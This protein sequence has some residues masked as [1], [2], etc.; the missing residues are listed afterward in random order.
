MVVV[1]FG[2]ICRYDDTSRLRWHNVEFEPNRSSFHL[3]FEKR[4]N[5]QFR[6]RNRVTVVPSTIGPVFPLKLLEMMRLHTGGGGEDA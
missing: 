3:S 6:K 1:M 2:D 5:D 4:K